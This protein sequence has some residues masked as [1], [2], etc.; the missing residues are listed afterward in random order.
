M[1]CSNSPLATFSA[2]SLL[3]SPAPPGPR[4][5]ESFTIHLGSQLKQTHNIRIAA[6]DLLELCRGEGAGGA[7]RDPSRRLQT[8]LA[9]Y[10]GELA[11]VVLL[12]DSPPPRLAPPTTQLLAAAHAATEHH[13]ADADAQ[14][15]LVVAQV[16]DPVS[17]RPYLSTICHISRTSTTNTT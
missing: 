10:S 2:D 9:L 15:R 7:G 5:E 12:C 17:T 14:L 8:S 6:M 16:K 13:F 3:Y 11:G 4:L 1:P